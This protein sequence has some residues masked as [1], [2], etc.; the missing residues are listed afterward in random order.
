MA[1]HT[2]YITSTPEK[3]SPSPYTAMGVYE[4]IKACVAAKSGSKNLK[5]IRVAVQGLGQVGMP[6]TETLFR[7]GASLWVSDLEQSR[8]DQAVSRFD[9]RFCPGDTIIDADVDV[10]APCGLGG[11]ITRSTI[12]RLK[13]GIIAGSAN[14]QLH[15]P[16]LAQSLMERDIL[17]APDYVINSGGLIYVAMTY[18]GKSRCEIESKVSAIGQTLTEILQAAKS[19]NRPPAFL[20]EDK[21][22][23]ILRQS[24]L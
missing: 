1:T 9:A 18:H 3:G 15:E 6:L 22:K 16:G 17:Y 24:N 12:E 2:A 21:A 14:N 13:C 7:A 20:A 4:G 5:G 19:A 8:T 10:F 23:A 11:V